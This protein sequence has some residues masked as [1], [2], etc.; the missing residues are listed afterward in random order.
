MMNRK[1]IEIR[2]FYPCSTTI[3]DRVTNILSQFILAVVSSFK[4]DKSKMYSECT[5]N[6]SRIWSRRIETIE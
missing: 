6:K 1:L 5:M 2:I 3:R 4:I